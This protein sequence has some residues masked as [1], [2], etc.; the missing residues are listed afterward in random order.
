MEKDDESDVSDEDD[1]VVDLNQYAAQQRRSPM[2][3]GKMGEED[4]KLLTSR[5]NPRDS[6]PS[7]GADVAK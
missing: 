4:G 6:K 3:R 1:D 5:A 2:K 7:V